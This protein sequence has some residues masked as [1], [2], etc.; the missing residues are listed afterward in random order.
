MMLAGFILGAF[1]GATFGALIVALVAAA[2]KEVPREPAR[3]HRYDPKPG[4]RTYS[5]HVL[6]PGQLLNVRGVLEDAPPREPA[7]EAFGRYDRLT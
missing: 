7:N 4:A 1:V 5:V 2:D 3:V 6:Y